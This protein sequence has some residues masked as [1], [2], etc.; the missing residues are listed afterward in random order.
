[1]TIFYLFFYSVVVWQANVWKLKK[2]RV[3]EEQKGKSIKF[4]SNINYKKYDNDLKIP[5][6][7]LSIPLIFNFKLDVRS[8]T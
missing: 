7:G 5:R 2:K 3:K 1:M 6:N 8:D 4:L